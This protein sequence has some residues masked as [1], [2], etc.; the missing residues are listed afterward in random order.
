MTN[1][2][3]I[4]WIVHCLWNYFAIASVVIIWCFIPSYEVHLSYCAYTIIIGS[5]FNFM[6][7]VLGFYQEQDV[8]AFNIILRVTMNF[9]KNVQWNQTFPSVFIAISSRFLYKEM[10]LHTNKFKILKGCFN[11]L[12]PVDKSFSFSHSLI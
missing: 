5:V 10:M 4:K 2:F 7:Q 11:T 9:T 8:W 6:F 12:E 3:L 1:L